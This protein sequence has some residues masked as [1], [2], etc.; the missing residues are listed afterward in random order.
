VIDR[1]P[2]SG[3]PAP[4]RGK[5]QRVLGTFV[6]MLGAG[7]ILECSAAW[8]GAAV[9]LAGAAAAGWGMLASAPAR[10]LTGSSDGVPSD[11]RAES[12]L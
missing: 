10:T 2:V 9:M 1:T 3:A 6:Y 8:T 11:S 7:I 4:L 12:R 5:L